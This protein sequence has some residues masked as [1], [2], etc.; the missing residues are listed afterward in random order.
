MN[1]QLNITVDLSDRTVEVLRALLS[2]SG[3]EK[4]QAPAVSGAPAPVKDIKTAKKPAPAKP[5]ASAA[6]A[7]G[8]A[9]VLDTNTSVEERLD[10]IRDK[11]IALRDKGKKEAT[12]KLMQDYNITKL[13]D[14]PEASLQ[15]FYNDLHKIK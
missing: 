3:A 10:I 7:T 4:P 1:M 12:V 8:E 14:L 5:E 9:G 15:D 13:T 6:D 11:T 2:V